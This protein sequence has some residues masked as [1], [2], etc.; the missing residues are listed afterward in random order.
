MLP[1]FSAAQM[2]VVYN[3]LDHAAICTDLQSTA[4]VWIPFRLPLESLFE[5]IVSIPDPPRILQRFVDKWRYMTY[6]SHMRKQMPPHTPVHSPSQEHTGPLRERGR[7]RRWGGGSKCTPVVPRD[8]QENRG[9][10]SRRVGTR[11]DDE[12][13]RHARC[14]PGLARGLRF[15]PQGQRNREESFQGNGKEAA[16][17]GH[18]SSSRHPILMTSFE[19]KFVSFFAFFL[20]SRRGTGQSDCSQIFVKNNCK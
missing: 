6:I 17:P 11:G 10:C 12:C 14:T 4:V 2:Y 7:R 5:N 8:V 19:F 18:S 13:C 15:H 3:H 20:I 1:P 16:T 9:V